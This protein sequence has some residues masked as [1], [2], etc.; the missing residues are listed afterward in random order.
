MLNRI[1][2]LCLLSATTALMA[3][4]RATPS[5]PL[6]EVIQHA[7]RTAAQQYEWMLSHQP[8]NGKMPRTFE[9]GKLVT[10]LEKDWTVG[11]FPGSLWL[12]WEATGE[13]RWLGAARQYTAM[14]E[15][16]QHNKR[17]H[18][19][20]FILQCSFGQ[21]YRLTGDEKYRPVL[22]QG[23]VS[24]STRY[25]PVVQSIKSW[26]R[27]PT[28]YT[29]PVIIDNMM[30]LELLLWA[31]AH[32]GPAQARV[33]ALA[34]ANTTLKNHFRPDGSSWHV[35]DYDDAD[36]RVLRRITHQGARDDSAW[37]R[38]QAWALYGYTVMFRE[39]REPRYLQQ[40]EKVA[41]FIMQ[42]PRLPADLVP[43]W[44][45]DAA[46][47]PREPRDASAAAIICSALFELSTLVEGPASSAY[48]GFAERQ[49]RSLASPE[50]LAEPG[51]NGGFILKHAT[52]NF[53]KDSEVDV[54]LNYADYYFLEA[55]NRGRRWVKL[56]DHGRP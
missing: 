18:D 10:V 6:S 45:F 29:F 13:E 12:L 15:A 7:A 2:L 27:P 56:L 20:G 8:L 38:G 50:Y 30:N 40:A 34:H 3:E 25:S 51:T 19:V 46:G 23:A 17:T 52:G 31:A 43:Y 55:L 22:L 37:A 32:G 16:E 28:V 1:F 39:T 35:V 47:I 21:G 26:D 54:P 11:F 44:D 42:H 48:A 36:G 9:H 53:P 33:I 24:L 49:L 14:L 4:P 5:A 41:G